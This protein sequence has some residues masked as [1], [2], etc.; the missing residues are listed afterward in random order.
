MASKLIQVRNLADET[1]QYTYLSSAVS[2]GGTS[3]PVR[4]I[5]AFAPSWAIQFGRTGEE[6]AEILILGTAAIAGTALTT[7]GTSRHTHPTDTPVFAIK[8]DKL[9][10]KRSTTGTAGVATAM[11]DGTVTI[12]PDSEFTVFDD[13]T[14]ASGYA[15][16]VAYYNSV[17]DVESD[18]SAWILTTGFSFYSLGAI[19]QRVKNRLS[20]SGY[21]KDDAVIDDWANEWLDTLNNAAIEVNQDYGL[22][23]VDVAFG[24][25][26]LGTVT[27]T[28]FK[29]FRKIEFT[30]NG[31]DW[32][33]S[34]KIHSI[35]FMPDEDFSETHP[36]HWYFGDNVIGRL[37]KG[38]VGTARVTYYKI[39]E[40]LSSDSD[41]VPVLMQP[42]TKSFVDYMT[43]QAYYMDE[44]EGMGDR[45]MALANAEKDQ[46]V[47]QITPRSA[48][49]PQYIK[50]TE[51]ISVDDTDLVL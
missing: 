22:G 10:F 25:D 29:E 19:R 42:Y 1:A 6:I 45:Y 32:Y 33:V 39:R 44:K 27:S 5:N 48:T 12:T 13:T 14:N 47:M 51:Q 49:G 41:E 31:T 2:V 23:T 21:I 46:F 24:T 17:L 15:Y 16:K 9:I 34:N 4:N 43:A 7:T 28:D 38:D 30:T 36:Y 11:T 18:E 20:N 37:P 8:Y 3:F 35:D 50:L 40:H 26:G